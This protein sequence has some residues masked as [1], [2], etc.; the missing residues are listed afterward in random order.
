[1]NPG[2]L[3]MYMQ[4]LECRNKLPKQEITHALVMPEDVP[5]NT[6]YNDF[7]SELV[8][9]DGRN[10]FTYNHLYVMLNTIVKDL[11]FKI[12]TVSLY[13][14]QVGRKSLYEI[15]KFLQLLRLRGITKSSRALYCLELEFNEIGPEGASILRE[16]FLEK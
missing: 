16:C 2:F 3:Q 12:N 14:A 4:Y 8:I 15:Q 13:K 11:G 5:F 10:T 6:I 9:V 7:Q 1:M